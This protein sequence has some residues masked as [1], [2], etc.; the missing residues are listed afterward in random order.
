LRQHE[1]VEL[2]W[3][4]SE[5]RSYIAEALEQQARGDVDYLALRDERGD[6]L[7]MTGVSYTGASGEATVWQMLVHPRLRRLGLGR[8]LLREAEQFASARGISRLRL[9][10]EPENR[11]A[12]RLYLELGYQL[13]GHG[14]ESWVER[15][16]EKRV[17]V[18]RLVKELSMPE[19][20]G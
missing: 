20:R 16:Q 15:N 4:D 19:R 17:R 13:S 6:V 9:A 12:L 1:L 18:L 11:A 3:V 7:A 14:W 8:H 10:V 2:T 5:H